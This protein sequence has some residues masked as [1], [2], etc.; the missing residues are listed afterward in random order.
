MTFEVDHKVKATVCKT[1]HHEIDGAM[2]GENS[3]NEGD[4]SVCAYCATIGRYTKEG[5]IEPMSKGALE[6]M[7]EHDSVKYNSL[8]KVVLMIKK[9]NNDKS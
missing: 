8:Q 9:I 7:E 1:C 6:I 2:G 4:F 5:Q 3:P